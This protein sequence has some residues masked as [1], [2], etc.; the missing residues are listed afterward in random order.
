MSDLPEQPEQSPAPPATEVQG[1]D[2]S[3]STG[4][5]SNDDGPRLRIGRK[6]VGAAVA[7]LCVAAG[8]VG[9]LLGARAVARHDSAKARQT[10]QQSSAGIASTL[11][12]GIQHEEDLLISASTFFAGKPKASA[13]ELSTWV[14]WAQALRRYP[15]LQKLGFVALVRAPE[16]A[17][18]EAQITGHATKTLR[19]GVVKPVGLQSTLPAKSAALPAKSLPAKS[20]LPAGGYLS[21]VPPG[22]RSFYC[23][24]AAELARNPA[25]HTRAS[26]DYCAH[27]PG[28]LSSRDS[29]LSIY[30]PASAGRSRGLEVQAPVYR[31]NLPPSGLATRRGAFVGWL[32]EVL[33]PGVM[34][35][36]VLRSHPGYALHL[37]YKSGSAKTAF[38]AGAPR[39]GAQSTTVA[40]HN[41]WTVRTFGPAL[42]SAS[43]LSHVDALALLLGGILLSVLLGLLAFLL[44]RGA[45]ARPLT[46]KTREVPHEDLYDALTGVPNR[47]LLMDRAGR[48]IARAVRDPELLV[49]ALVIDVDWFKDIND[50]L[51]EAAGDQVL[52]IVAERLE[53]V[54]RTHDSVGRLEGD[55]FVVLVEA[56]A[57]GAR[58]DAL[59][60][61]VIE[62]LHK[63]VELDGFGP[64]FFVTASI[65]IAY[66][67]HASADELLR[68]AHL[69]LDAAKAAGKDRYTLF[70]AN[71][72]SVIEGQAVLGTELNAALADEQFLLLY[73]PIY[74]LGTR[75][76]VGLEALIRWVHPSKGVLSPADFIPLA[77]ETGL[78]VPIGRWA[79]EEACNRAAAW[80]V[81]GHQVGISVMVSANQ[82][83][84]DGFA[85]DVRR[86]LQQSGIEPSLLTLEI[87]EGTVMRDVAATTERLKEIKQLGVRVAI[88]DFGSGYAYR[89]D[90]QRM[91]V[92]FLKVDRSS[93]AASEDEDY[94]SWLLEAILLFGRELSLRVIAKGIETQEQLT[95]LE[96][97]GCTLAQGFFLG[98]PAPANAVQGLLDADSTTAATSSPSLPH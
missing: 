94:R 38:A 50:K 96:T 47:A 19:S 13:A 44:G 74:D 87:A 1:T 51:G 27:T 72:R 75:K 22:T 39:P 9:S 46:P 66:G 2:P 61:R 52:G 55:Q 91:P 4:L 34:L 83:D 18:F 70:N 53:S 73:Q 88:D 85:T 49:G 68:D 69:A 97:M 16:L 30:A 35:Q 11:K 62:A 10:F 76:V 26:H 6:T 45:P 92:D 33:L 82:L 78:I 8:T 65:G 79:L 90:L 5:P 24:S 14:K 20:S 48:M 58:L 37:R 60:R 32:R 28:L 67:R 59:A 86:A 64:S 84:R 80:N 17:A 71:M 25:H 29:A 42:A 63:P 81:T 95:A 15:E 7:V 93:L 54:V 3:E 41:A 56:K 31:G 21:I 57:R 43:A 23:L 40:L 77:E 12:Q 36:Q 98:E 89:S